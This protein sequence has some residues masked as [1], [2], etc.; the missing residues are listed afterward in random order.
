MFL[1]KF[2]SRANHYCFYSQTLCTFVYLN[3]ST[4]ACNFE[5]DFCGWTNVASDDFDWTRHHGTT[6]STNTGP[7]SDHT[8]R[9]AKGFIVLMNYFDL[10]PILICK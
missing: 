7:P 4:G 1:C 5:K 9:N 3:I 10:I 8:L 6:S 2:K